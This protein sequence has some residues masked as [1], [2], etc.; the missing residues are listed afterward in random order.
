MNEKKLQT[1]TQQFTNATLVLVLATTLFFG[2]SHHAVLAQAVDGTLN[3][4]GT[5]DNRILTSDWLTLNPGEQITYQVA[6][7]G[8]EQPI[9]IW[10]NTIPADGAIFQIWNDDRLAE[11]AEDAETEPLGQGTAMNEGSGFTNWQGGSP[12][13]DIYYVVVSATGDST[14]RFLLNVSS[15]ALALE[16]PGAIAVGSTTVGDPNIAVVT[17][18]LLNVRSGPSTTFPIITTVP[19][20]T[21]MTVLGR[22]AT[23]TWLNVQLA[24]GTEGWVTRSLTNYI[25]VSPNVIGGVD[26]IAAS[27]GATV[28]ATATATTTVTGTESVTETAE[29]TTAP[30][31]TT[32]AMTTTELA[33]GWRILAPGERAW[34]TFQYRGGEL[35]LTIWMDM[36]PFESAEFTV[37]DAESA[38]AMMAD[39][40]ATVTPIGNGRPNPLEAGYLFWQAEFDEADTFYVMVEADDQI[41]VGTTDEVLYSIYALGPGVG[42]VVEAV[43]SEE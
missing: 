32:A 29:N 19:N 1:L 28:T 43:E 24:D 40:N 30:I 15:P 23:N 4:L 12:E 26:G 5:G 11:L 35:P 3:D 33:A 14:V 7:D 6:Y 31:T 36:E 25:T 17:T 13:A 37:M 42:R 41:T 27:V 16:Q 8:D 10:M 22:N 34:Y 21:E 2:T 9:L 39:E 20:G 38:Q 18:G